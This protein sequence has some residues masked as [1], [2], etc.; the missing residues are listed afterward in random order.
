MSTDS[1]V[2]I[3]PE[4][5]STDNIQYLI[6]IDGTELAFVETERDA[7]LVV[8]SL[9]AEEA[10][11][12]TDDW[13]KVYR[14]DLNGGRKVILSTQALGRVMNGSIVPK[15]EID[16]IAVGHVVL[17]RGRHERAEETDLNETPSVPLPELLEKIAKTRLGDSAEKTEEVAE[18]KTEEVS[19]EN[20]PVQTE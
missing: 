15:E 16:C 14:E 10:R 13:T 20:A 5:R 4:V 17:V 9:A 11:R 6:R 3:T 12:L 19:S 7:I 18:E 8:D 1:G 2:K